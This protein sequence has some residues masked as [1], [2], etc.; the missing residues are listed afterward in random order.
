MAESMKASRGSLLKRLALVF[1]L[2]D[3]YCKQEALPKQL[4]YEKISGENCFQTLSLLL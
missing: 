3:K 2:K 1:N 4:A